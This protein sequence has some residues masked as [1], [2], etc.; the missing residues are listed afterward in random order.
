MQIY[1]NNVSSLRKNGLSIVTI[2]DTTAP[3][4]NKTKFNQTTVMQLMYVLKLGVR[5]GQVSS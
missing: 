5:H 3:A 4:R 1:P 2:S